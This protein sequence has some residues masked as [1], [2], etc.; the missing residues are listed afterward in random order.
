[1]ELGADA[2]VLDLG[3]GSV[4]ALHAYRE[5]SELRAVVVSHLHPDHHVDLVPLRHLLKYGYPAERHVELHAPAE[6]RERYDAFLGEPGFLDG[7]PGPDLVAGLRRIGPFEVQAA[8]VRHALHSHAVRVSV[9]DQGDGPG[10][11]YSGDCGR[12]DDLLPL[13]RPGD[14]L[15]CEAFW[16]ADPDP[17]P[18]AEHL[19][20]DDAAS[21]AARSGA[22]H[23]VLTHIADAHRP[24]EALAIARR[25]YS[26]QV[27]LAR[28]GLA[29]DIP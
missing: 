18:A 26:G 6:L 2:I 4:G 7:L 15:L 27:D 16:G 23:L 3:Q 1:V 5:P 12:A 29:V 8:P 19:T 13:I 20:A 25:A 10:L 11:V 9:A 17:E 21:V 22:A 24:D 14:T 28:P